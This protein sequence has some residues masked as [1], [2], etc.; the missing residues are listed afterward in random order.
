MFMG[1]E[2]LWLWLCVWPWTGE[3]YDPIGCPLP[4]L[5]PSS[6]P[7]EFRLSAAMP[8]GGPMGSITPMVRIEYL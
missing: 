4:S 8:W 6:A 2:T 1:W 7:G 3:K 5:F